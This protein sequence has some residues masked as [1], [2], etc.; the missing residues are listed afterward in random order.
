MKIKLVK[1]LILL[2]ILV[3]VVDGFGTVSNFKE[4]SGSIKFYDSQGTLFYEYV[5]GLT[6]YQTPVPLSNYPKHI[7]E[8]AVSTEDKRF[9]SHL[10]IDPLGM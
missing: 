6:G 5:N 7:P 1:V 8:L 3:S 9:Y 4:K 10:G 2:V